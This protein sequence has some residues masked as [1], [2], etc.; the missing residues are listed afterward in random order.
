MSKSY[1]YL[2]VFSQLSIV[3]FSGIFIK[4]V[5]RSWVFRIISKGEWSVSGLKIHLQLCLAILL[6]SPCS[7]IADSV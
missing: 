1:R 3:Q 6:P 2:S 7:V 4:Y 5:K